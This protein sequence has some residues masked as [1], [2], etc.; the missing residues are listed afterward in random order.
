M[1]Q[2]VKYKPEGQMFPR[3]MFVI[4]NSDANVRKRKFKN[5]L[6]DFDLEYESVCRTVQ[7]FF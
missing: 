5:E 2:T 3:V 7:V 6:M 4:E 1:K